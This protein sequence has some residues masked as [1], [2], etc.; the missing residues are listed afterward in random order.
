M[1]K[2]REDL[3]WESWLIAMGS[4]P[5]LDICPSR[6]RWTT[7]A[8]TLAGRGTECAI[9]NEPM[10]PTH[11]HHA[12]ATATAAAVGTTVGKDG[13]YAGGGGVHGGR[14]GSGSGGVARRGESASQRM[15]RR[16]LKRGT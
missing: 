14:G 1:Q 4:A 15:L 6:R 7:I 5:H 8:D 2:L 3:A 9:C 11:E 16:G 12:T 10:R 13:S